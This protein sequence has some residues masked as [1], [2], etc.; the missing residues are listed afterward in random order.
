M[1]KSVAAGAD[2]ATPEREASPAERRKKRV[3]DQIIEAAEEVFAAEGAGG[4]SMRRL[5]EKIDY[6]PAAIYKYFASKGELVQEIR[7]QFFDRLLRRLD[8]E[9][10]AKSDFARCLRVYVECG[11]ERPNHYRMAF[12]VGEEVE[13]QLDDT[14][15]AFQAARHLE[16]MIAE[17]VHEGRFRPVSLPVAAASVWSALHGVTILMADL[18]E[19]PHGEFA[20]EPLSNDDVIDFHVDM[21]ERGL[22]AR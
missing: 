5:A 11:L 7:E 4:L 10:D 2:G 9:R 17:G 8:R 3:R 16:A 21:I 15:N 12:E 6:S 13:K 14:S 19:F 1:A 18:R 20:N 22:S